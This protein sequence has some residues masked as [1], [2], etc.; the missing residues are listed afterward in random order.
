MVTDEIYHWYEYQAAAGSTD[1]DLNRMADGSIDGIEAV[2]ALRLYG[3]VQNERPSR[4][5]DILK[6]RAKPYDWYS[7]PEVAEYTAKAIKAKKKYLETERDGEDEN[8]EDVDDYRRRAGLEKGTVTSPALCLAELDAGPN[9][10][11]ATILMRMILLTL[12][13]DAEKEG[14]SANAAAFRKKLEKKLRSFLERATP[15]EGLDCELVRDFFEK[16]KGK[17]L[18]DVIDFLCD[19]FGP[20]IDALAKR[21]YPE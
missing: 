12:A 13:E 5:L 10:E 20:E 19:C 16:H 15:D 2:T 17:K 6:E 4:W 18:H 14:S 11:Y 1:E 7:I 3:I 9:T 8:T 21:C